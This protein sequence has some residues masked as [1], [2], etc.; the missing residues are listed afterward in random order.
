MQK[1]VLH[2]NMDIFTI[3]QKMDKMLLRGEPSEEAV[4]NLDCPKQMGMGSFEFEKI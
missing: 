3:N 4:L 2:K 1:P